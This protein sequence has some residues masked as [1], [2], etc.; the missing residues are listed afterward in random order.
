MA[1]AMQLF[2]LNRERRS[3]LPIL[4]DRFRTE[5]D[6]GVREFLVKVVWERRDS[7]IIP[8]PA[9]ALYDPSPAVWKQSLDGWVTFASGDAEQVLLAARSRSFPSEVQAREFREWID[10]AIEHVQDRS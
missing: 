3:I 8:F 4:V 7:S 2:W 9:E 5:A 10:E 6:S 1:N